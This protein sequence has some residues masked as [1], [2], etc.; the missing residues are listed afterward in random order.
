M[1]LRNKPRLEDYYLQLEDS[2]LK[3][4]IFE[5]DARVKRDISLLVEALLYSIDPGLEG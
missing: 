3:V 1:D 2:G 4:P 5:V